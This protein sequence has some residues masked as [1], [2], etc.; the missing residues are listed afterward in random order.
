MAFVDGHV[1]FVFD[2]IDLN[3]YQAKASIAGGEVINDK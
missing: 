1:D 3:A 2:D